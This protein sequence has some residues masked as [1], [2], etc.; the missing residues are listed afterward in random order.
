MPLSL[1]VLVAGMTQVFFLGRSKYLFSDTERTMDCQRIE[2]LLTEAKT[3]LDRFQSSGKEAARIDAQQKAIQLVHA[4]ERPRDAILKLS[5]S[6][7]LT[8]KHGLG[9]G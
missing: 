6:V 7:S 2:S 1:I 8:G 9:N 5:F 4:L 3:Y